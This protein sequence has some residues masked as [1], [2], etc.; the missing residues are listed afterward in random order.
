MSVSKIIEVYPKPKEIEVKI[1][2][3]FDYIAF[4]DSGEDILPFE[5]Y[6][7]YKKRDMLIAVAKI[8]SDSCESGY[9]FII[10]D[11]ELEESGVVDVSLFQDEN[12]K[13]D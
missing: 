5:A 12:A 10:F 1:D 13:G 3:T 2:F 11:E 7:R 9:G 4:D 6:K 8:K